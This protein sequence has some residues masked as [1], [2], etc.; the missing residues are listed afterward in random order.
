MKIDSKPC[1]PIFDIGERF[2]KDLLQKGMI[3]RKDIRNG[4][5]LAKLKVKINYRTIDLSDQ[6]APKKLNIWVFDL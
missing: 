3:S 2:A 5:K 4:L 1:L 6:I